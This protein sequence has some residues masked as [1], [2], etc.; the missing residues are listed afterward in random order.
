MSILGLSGGGGNYIR[1]QPSINAWIFDKEELAL[2]KVLFDLDSV[3][4]GWGLMME[5]QAPTWVWDQ[6]LGQ[7]AP[8]P[9]GEFK[10]GFSVRMYLGPQRGWAEWSSTGTGPCMGFE[11]LYDVALKDM[12]ANEG[13]ALV[14]TYTG[15]RAEKIGKGNTRVPLF[16]VTGW[17]DKPADDSG[18]DEAPAP[19][20][21]APKSP[22][23]TGSKPVGAPQK[24][25]AMADSEDFG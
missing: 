15:S 25:A 2:K 14:A 21:A 10:R 18:E 9:E 20:A 6:G 3:K 17:A 11:A 24:K 5:G 19:K 4:T 16:E 8:K 23:S 13:M 22:P 1:F 12:A 7:R